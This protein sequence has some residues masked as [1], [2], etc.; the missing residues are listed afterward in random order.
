MKN[1]K[2]NF[3]LVGLLVIASFLAGSLWTKI[4]SEKS[5]EEKITGSQATPAAPSFNPKKSARPEVK[6]FVM[7]F[8]PFGNQ[9]EAGLEPVYQLLK[10]KVNWQPRYIVSDKKASCEQSCPFRVWNDQAKQRCQSGVDAGQVKSL[11]DCRKQYFPY[12]SAEECLKK[13]CAGIKEGEWESLHGDGELHQDIREICAFQ[14]GDLEK[15]WKFVSLVNQKCNAQN[16]DSCWE[17]QAKEAGLEVEKIKACEK[18][19]ANE[20]LKKEVEE[21]EKYQASGSPTVF[22]NET[23]YNGGRAPEDYKKAICAAFEKQPKECQTVLGAETQAPAAG[24][25]R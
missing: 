11:E 25:C 10:D 19:K 1:S 16:A 7:S 24:G 4:R 3:I 20:L 5:A 18:E 6:F 22:I 15:W 8:C 13:A 21:A 12:S 23:L 2:I 9:A 17:G 14:L